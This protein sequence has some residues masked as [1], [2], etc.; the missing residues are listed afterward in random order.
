MYEK[1]RHVCF[2][3]IIVQLLIY[4]NL[5]FICCCLL[6]EVLRT[7]PLTLCMNTC[8]NRFLLSIYPDIPA[9]EEKPSLVV[10]ESEKVILTRAINSNPLSNV[11]W[12]K[13]TK[14]LKNQTLV[15]NA[16]YAIE[17]ATCT[18]TSNYTLKASNGIGNI[19]T[20]RVELIVNCK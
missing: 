8:N 1:R 19:V 2:H 6:Q 14:P 13:G 10:N 15:S 4:I 5:Q 18:D 12:F 7:S 17:N 11:Y 9:I 20:S 16:S 3:A